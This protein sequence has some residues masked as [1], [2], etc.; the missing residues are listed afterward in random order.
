VFATAFRP[1]ARAVG[2]FTNVLPGTDAKFIIKSS[3]FLQKF[4][5]AGQAETNAWLCF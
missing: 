2:I 5:D 3:L 1:T 4:K